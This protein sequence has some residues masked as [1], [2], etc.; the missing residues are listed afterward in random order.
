ML[1]VS[2][3]G[4][5]NNDWFM[6]L[7]VIIL[8]MS[9]ILQTLYK[10]ISPVRNDVKSEHS[11]SSDINFLGYFMTYGGF[12]LYVHGVFYNRTVRAAMGMVTMVMSLVDMRAPYY[13]LMECRPENSSIDIN[14]NYA[15]TKH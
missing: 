12:F 7:F 9:K 8:I 10:P 5:F 11:H 3:S 1:D 4:I 13:N 6:A 14:R 2:I 15:S